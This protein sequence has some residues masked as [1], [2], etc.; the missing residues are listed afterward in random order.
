[1]EENESAEQQQQKLQN[2]LFNHAYETT[3][4]KRNK[5]RY[6]FSLSLFNYAIHISNTFG[7]MSLLASGA[8]LQGKSPQGRRQP[9]IKEPLTLFH[10]GVFFS[11]FGMGGVF[12][13]LIIS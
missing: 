10:M 3:I 4:T 13:P 9:Q 7:W 1:M 11:D 5:S 12:R 2:N 6:E 8:S